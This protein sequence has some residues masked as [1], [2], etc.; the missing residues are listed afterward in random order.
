MNARGGSNYTSI[1]RYP[2]S[3]RTKEFMGVFSDKE[4]E[5]C[6]PLYHRIP[7]M[8]GSPGMS[9]GSAL[10]GPQSLL[11][12]LSQRPK[13]LCAFPL[14]ET[15]LVLTLWRDRVSPRLLIQRKHRLQMVP[16][17]FVWEGK[18]EGFQKMFFSQRPTQSFLQSKTTATQV[19]SALQRQLFCVKNDQAQ[20]NWKKISFERQF[21]IIDFQNSGVHFD[22]VDLNTLICLI[23]KPPELLVECHRAK[24]SD[25]FSLLNDDSIWWNYQTE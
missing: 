4:E 7:S 6:V 14:N 13:P 3:Q 19:I 5:K 1:K 9:A 23:L 10:L 24:C 8:P 17:P 2:F 18:E 16:S 21:L 15:I 12:A 22:W 11:I 20:S 25:Q